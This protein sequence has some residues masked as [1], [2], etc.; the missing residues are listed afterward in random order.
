ME[1]LFADMFVEQKRAA[2]FDKAFSY[3]FWLVEGFF[4]C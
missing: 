3:A 2:A 1:L 4:Y